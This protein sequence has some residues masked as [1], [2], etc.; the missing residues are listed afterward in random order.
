MAGAGGAAEASVAPGFRSVRPGH[1]SMLKRPQETQSG[2]EARLSLSRPGAQAVGMGRQLAESLPAARALLR[3]GE[4]RCSAMIW[5]RSALRGQRRRSIR[6]FTASRRCSSR[7]WPR[8][9]SLKAAS[10]ES[11]PS[12]EAA[13]GLSLRRV[14]GTRVRRRDGIRG[15]VKGGPRTR[16]RDASRQRCR[17]ERNGQHLGTRSAAGRG[18]LPASGGKAKCC[19]SPTCFARETSPSPV[20]RPLASESSRWPPMQEPCEPFPLAV[21]GAFHTPIM[22]PAVE[23]LTAALADVPLR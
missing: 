10:P 15:R 1:A 19:R 22:Q 13:A 16:R 17:A 18:T 5:P 20:Q 7:A 23:R 14:H 4:S 2:D 9:E 21:A 12:A 6:L 8:L 3:A 11:S